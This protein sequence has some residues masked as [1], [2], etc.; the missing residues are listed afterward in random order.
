M[1]QT[2]AEGGVEEEGIRHHNFRRNR[3]KE[4]RNHREDGLITISDDSDEEIVMLTSSPVQEQID[5]DDEVIVLE[6]PRQLP[7]RPSI[8]RPAALWKSAKPSDQ[9]RHEDF[10]AAINKSVAN[11]LHFSDRRTLRSNTEKNEGPA[12][13]ENG[14]FSPPLPSTSHGLQEQLKHMQEK[15]LHSLH[16]N[17]KKECDVITLEEVEQGNLHQRKRIRETTVNRLERELEPN[18][19]DANWERQHSENTVAGDD[20]FEL[21]DNGHYAPQGRQAESE[22]LDAVRPAE[23]PPVVI[24]PL[25]G[26]PGPPFFPPMAHA[27]EQPRGQDVLHNEQP[28]PAFP[29]QEVADDGEADAIEGASAVDQELVN[30]L[31]KETVARFPDVEE[32][33]VADLIL[34]RR[35]TDL[36][37]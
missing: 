6:P 31:L 5:D 18:L 22:Q 23:F 13:E 19:P 27:P 9:G 36:N 29:G 33:F 26:S 11:H 16:P 3:G 17:A 32:K 10:P 30:A 24:R 35:Y 12:R 15:K 8:I 34:N 25:H 37:L 28:G 4:W 21:L 14:D 2:M 7:N 20:D 1:C